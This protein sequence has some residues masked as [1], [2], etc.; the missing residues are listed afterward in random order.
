MIWYRFLHDTITLAYISLLLALPL[1]TVIY[2]VIM[3]K[4]RQHFHFISNLMKFIMLTG[5]L[6]S[7]VAGAIITSGK[8]L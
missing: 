7:L 6:Y 1:V 8:I 4:E 2:K 3:G 5:I